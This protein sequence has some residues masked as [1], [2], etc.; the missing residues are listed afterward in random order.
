MNIKKGMEK[1][2]R[3][4]RRGSVGQERGEDRRRSVENELQGDGSRLSSYAY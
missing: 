4:V 1:M 2:E 3:E